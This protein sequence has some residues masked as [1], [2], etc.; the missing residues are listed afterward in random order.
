MAHDSVLEW[1]KNP[2]TNTDGVPTCVQK[3]SE[4]IYSFQFLKPEINKLFLEELDHIRKFF[5]DNKIPSEAPNPQNKHGVILDNFN[6]KNIFQLL[7]NE[8]I[9]PISKKLWHG[10]GEDSLDCHNSFTTAYS[11]NQDTELEAHIDDSEISVNYCLEN[12]AG[13]GNVI[14]KG[15]RCRPHWE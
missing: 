9:T 12:H 6:F 2:K 4:G 11:E 10:V 14:F 13:G 8:I 3:H 7:I 1:I 5:R 15:V